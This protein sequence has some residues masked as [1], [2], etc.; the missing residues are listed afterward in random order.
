MSFTSITGVQL[1]LRFSANNMQH[2]RNVN[3]AHNM[4][5]TST[6]KMSI[7][8]ILSSVVNVFSLI[9]VF[10]IKLALNTG[11]VLNQI[12]LVLRLF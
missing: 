12:N 2:Q 1:P 5:S 10:L 9:T 3:K 7:K 11:F 8:S 6:Y 4:S